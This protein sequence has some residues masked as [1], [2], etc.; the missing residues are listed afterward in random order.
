MPQP[1]SAPA[2]MAV[3]PRDVWALPPL[4]LYVTRSAAAP[5]TAETL[6]NETFFLFGVER[7]LI[8]DW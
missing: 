4:G 7:S 8:T 2:C 6:D 3:G 5:A 1:A